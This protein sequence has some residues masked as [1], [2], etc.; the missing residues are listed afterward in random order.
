MLP[1]KKIPALRLYAVFAL[2][3]M[4]QMVSAAQTNEILTNAADV[5][6]LSAEQASHWIKISVKGVVTAAEPSWNG[7]FFVQDSS[8]GVFVDNVNGVQPS[9]GDLVAVSGISYPGGYAP[10]ITAPHCKKLGTAPLPAAKVVTIEQFMS[11]TEDSQRVQISGIVRTAFTNIDRLGV[12]LAAGGYRFRAYSPIPAGINPQALVGAKM[13]VEGTAAVAFNAPLRHFITVVLFAPLSTDFTVEKPAVADP[14]KEPLTPLNG[15]AQYRKDRSSGNRV[16]VKGIVTYQR[17]G[18]D[19]FLQDSTG[20]LQVKSS[21]ATSC[22]PG[23]VV[24]AVGFPGVEN[25]LP[26]LEDAIFQKTSEPRV[27]VTPKTATAGGLLE[28]LHHA[29]FITLKGKLLDRVQSPSSKPDS[30]KIILMLQTTNLLFTAEKEVTEQSAFLTSIPIGSIVEVSGICMLQSEEDGKIKSIQILLPTS[31]DVRIISKPSWLTAQHLSIIL[32]VVFLSLII[33]ISWTIMVSQKN[34]ALRYLIREREIAQK[35]LQKA[36]DTLDWRVKER[37]KQLKFH[38]TARKESELQFRGVLTERT[39]LAQELHD[40]LEQTLTGIALQL[41]TVA[42]LFQ[43]D[44]EGASYH[45]GLVR[46]LMRKSQVD[47]RRSI[48]DLRSRELEEFDLSSA[49]LASGHQLADDAGIRIEVETKG[50][51]RPLPEVIEENLLRIGQEAITNAVKHSGAKLAKIELEF[52]PQNV[53]LEIKDDGKGFAPENCLG[54]D[55]GHF[56][57][58]GMSERAK[59][60]NGQ[61]SITSVPEKGT[62]IRVELPID[63]TQTYQVPEFMDEQADYEEGITNSDSRS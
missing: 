22:S 10:C 49:L 15:I 51:V 52:G 31:H 27:E 59:R 8:G 35:E 23:D 18:E 46:N 16:H 37:T 17:K 57:L 13:R 56:G 34:S 9:P 61:F 55:D 3:S 1:A 53:V 12:E 60:F 7:R 6:S 54:P 29:D 36:H 28:G 25:F 42:K 43:R 62:T 58:L 44:P 4:G 11:G 45:L 30:E 38:V 39:R 19:L 26:V 48:W 32:T 2:L 41:N 50:R 63:Q 20:G 33:A 5:L 47:L 40:T 24:E 14:F 21:Q